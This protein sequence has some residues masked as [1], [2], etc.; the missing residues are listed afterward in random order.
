MLVVESKSERPQDAA[1]SGS[2]WLCKCDCGAECVKMG[3]DLRTG[4]T[5]SCGCLKHKSRMGHGLT[6]TPEWNSWRGMVERCTN[7][8]H[9]NYNRYGGRGITVCDRWRKFENFLED[10][11]N[12]PDGCSIERIRNDEGYGPENCTWATR[13]Q[14]VRNTSASHFIE[15][16]GVR[17]CITDWA[18]RLGLSLA[19]LLWRLETW[20]TERA[21]TEIPNRK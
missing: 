8:N 4:D 1:R 12:R 10:M 18:R 7:P 2:F 9:K 11:G 16:N 15:H 14:Q 21:L 20:P 17:L 13:G 3:I 5:K 19:T 6:K